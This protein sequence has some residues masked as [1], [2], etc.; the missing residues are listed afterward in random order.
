[1]LEGD[2]ELVLRY[3]MDATPAECKASVTT[4]R[5]AR[6]L[7]LESAGFHAAYPIVYAAVGSVAG[8]CFVPFATDCRP[9]LPLLLPIADLEN[10][11]VQFV[12]AMGHM[13]FFT[14]DSFNGSVE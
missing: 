4:I 6:M 5:G 3:P 8:D 14:V 1:M 2:K 10:P 9:K 11:V 7:S 12:D 13:A